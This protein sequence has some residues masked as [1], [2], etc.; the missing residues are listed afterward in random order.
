MKHIMMI[1]CLLLLTGNAQAVSRHQ[2]DEQLKQGTY[3]V[4]A[5]LLKSEVDAAS[6]VKSL[7]DYQ[8]RSPYQLETLLSL[9]QKLVVAKF[10]ASDTYTMIVVCGDAVAALDGDDVGLGRLALQM[11][12][13]RNSHDGE[14]F[15]YLEWLDGVGLP[16]WDML[17]EATGKKASQMRELARDGRL[18]EDVVCSILLKQFYSKY[19]GMA[20]IVAKKRKK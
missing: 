3:E 7:S 20:E 5:R 19:E 9:A 11:A 6:L 1:L 8:P 12:G 16:V 17:A 10:S 4:L 13:L 2:D 14:A 18:K 15:Y